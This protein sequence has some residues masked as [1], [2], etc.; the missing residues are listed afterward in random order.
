MSKLCKID[1][2]F[3]YL[4]H[5]DQ[6]L[7]YGVDFGLHRRVNSKWPSYE[8]HGTFCCLLE[9]FLLTR[10]IQGYKK[11]GPDEYSGVCVLTTQKGTTM[12]LSPSCKFVFHAV[13]GYM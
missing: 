4:A 6:K 3:V 2:L 11:L 10:Y 5:I 12:I 7:C 8:P 13:C 9:Y 1:I